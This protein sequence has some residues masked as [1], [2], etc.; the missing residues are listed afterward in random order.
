MSKKYKHWG[1]VGGG[2]LGM[3]LAHRLAQQGHS[4]TL[5]E[6]ADQLGG[7]T[8]TWQL[9]EVIWDKYYHVIALS[10][11]YLRDLLREIGLESE[12]KWVS[13]KSGFY[14]DGRL[15]SMS[16]TIEFLTFPPLS[17]IDK[18][19]LGLTI[20]YASKVKNWKRLEG[21]HVTDWLRKWSGK[22]TFQKIWL[23]LLR[24]K[25]GE[26]Y[27]QTSA[28]FI[29]ATIQR[30]YAARRTGLKKEMFGYVEGGYAR[31]LDTFSRHLQA[32]GVQIR[33]GFQATSVVSDDEGGVVVESRSGESLVFDEVVLT[34]PSALAADLCKGLSAEEQE[35]H[36]QIEYLGVIC[37]SLLLRKSLSPFYVTNVT[38]NAPFTGVIEMTNLVD[39]EFF[40]GQSLLYLPKY[41]SRHDP[42]FKKS[43]EEIRELFWNTLK[44]M[45][46]ELRDEDLAAFQVTRAPNVFALSTIRYSEKLPPV[47]TAAA[48]VHIL[49][50]AHII[51]GTLNVNE[52]LQVV[53]RELPG[54]LRAA[55]SFHLLSRSHE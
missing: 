26:H 4:V 10:D 33:T 31:I 34:V 28:A 19:R 41:V 37:A 43:D 53:E 50:S 51:N 23:P 40:G 46:K 22:N 38:D 21:I 3:H 35:K 14:T 44:Q 6:G 1:V 20:F 18:F 13:T 15:Y 29:W 48:G 12:M 45:Y 27:E 24:A 49:N 5:L 39:P 47:S 32:E 9:G 55:G 25:L 36:R 42:F 16:D 54:L 2:M 7:L 52:T 8:A 11:T 17:L 30:M